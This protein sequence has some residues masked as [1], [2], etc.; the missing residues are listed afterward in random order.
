MTELLEKIVKKYSLFDSEKMYK[1][2][3]IYIS[4][5]EK[6]EL[7]DL[8][9]LL[10]GY[11]KIVY[12]EEDSWTRLNFTNRSLSDREKINMIRLDLKYIQKYG[13]RYYKKEEIIKICK[14][15]NVDFTTF[16]TYIYRYK[17][18]YYNNIEILENNK[19]GLWIGEKVKLS[20]S[21]ID[22]YYS[23][24]V[25]NINISASSL[26]SRYNCYHLKEKIIDKA[27]DYLLTLGTIEKNYI[28]D[29]KIA[30]NKIM[31]RLKYVMLKEIIKEQK[32]MYFDNENLDFIYSNKNY[33]YGACYSTYSNIISE[34]LF[35][36][37]FSTI[38]QIIIDEI[39]S[40]LDYFIEDRIKQLN[41]ICVI[42]SI[43]KE[44]LIR[45]IENIKN[46]L[47]ENN[48]VRITR[49]GGVIVR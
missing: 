30:I 22:R 15:Y 11:T 20:K 49:D 32:Y 42:L 47:I 44:K 23:E 26:V 46:V 27:K 34:W 41:N 8:V 24:I 38:E 40:R 48:R 45:Y 14:K 5:Q 18:C 43:G 31:Y 21:F 12:K 29:S 36:I 1:S 37:N 35:G 33:Q 16:I 7:K 3:L 4:N 6:I 9:Y 19:Y 2:D 28:Y 17:V 39:S 25:S 10:G 13:N